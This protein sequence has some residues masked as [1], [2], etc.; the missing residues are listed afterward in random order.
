[1]TTTAAHT[2]A[3]SGWVTPA[4]LS[5]RFADRLSAGTLGHDDLKEHFRSLD[6][7][8]LAGAAQGDCIAAL[9]A[10]I[11]AARK[12]DRLGRGLLVIGANVRA[13]FGDVDGAV[14]LMVTAR[15][16]RPEGF[17]GSHPQAAI[18]RL[19]TFGTDVVSRFLTELR[20]AGVPVEPERQGLEGVQTTA[21]ITAAIDELE[22][23]G[24]FRDVVAAGRAF[25]ALRAAS[26]RTAE[27]A[28]RLFRLA[29]QTV[30][31]TP[32]TL[33]DALLVLSELGAADD[34]AMLLDEARAAGV[35]PA[36]LH[37]VTHLTALNNALRYEESLAA[38]QA[39]L[40]EGHPANARAR[41]AQ[42]TA[43]CWAE[44]P[45][46][47]RAALR[48][49]AEAVRAGTVEDPAASLLTTVLNGLVHDDTGDM[50]DV[51]EHTADV[52]DW[53]DHHRQL[54]TS[55]TRR[56]RSLADHARALAA[57]SRL[58]RATQSELEA[59]VKLASDRHGDD[60]IDA[61]SRVCAA[62]PSAGV[63]LGLPLA[64]AQLERGDLAGAEETARSTGAPEAAEAVAFAY[65]AAGDMDGALRTAR[66][67]EPEGGSAPDGGPRAVPLPHPPA[68]I[69]K[70]VRVLAI[71]R[72][73]E[74]AEEWLAGYA[75][76]CWPA[77]A[78]EGLAAAYRRGKGNVSAIEGVMRRMRQ[79]GTR[80]TGDVWAQLLY[81]LPR[82][83]RTARVRDALRA[84]KY[85]RAQPTAAFFT[86][87]IVGALQPAKVRV[88]NGASA[89]AAAWE[90][91]RTA[92]AEGEAVLAQALDALTPPDGSG[93]LPERWFSPAQLL[94]IARAYPLTRRPYAQ[95][96]A[97]VEVRLAEE[98]EP[99][100]QFGAFLGALAAAHARAELTAGIARL[101]AI[102]ERV[103][104]ADRPELAEALL[105][106]LT[107]DPDETVR[108]VQ[109]ECQRGLLASDLVADAAG[110]ALA[111]TGDAAPVERVL[112]EAEPP[113]PEEQAERLVSV[114]VLAFDDAGQREDARRLRVAAQSRGL[115]LSPT[116]LGVLLAT[117]RPTVPVVEDLGPVWT[118]AQ[119]AAY[120]GLLH[121]EIANQLQI[122]RSR[123]RL[124]GTALGHLRANLPP[125]VA[126]ENARY[127]EALERVERALHENQDEQQRTIDKIVAA[128]DQERTSAGTVPVL[129]SMTVVAQQMASVAEEAHTTI[130][131]VNRDECARLHVRGHATLL[132]FA[133]HNLISNGIKAHGRFK[134]DVRR[135]IELMATFAESTREDLAVAPYGWVIVSVRDHGDGV[136]DDLPDNVANWSMPGQPGLGA[137]IGL[138]RTE[139]MI[140]LS[141]G[142]LWVDQSV[143][144]GSRFS[145]RLPSAA[146]RQTRGAQ[147]T[148]REDSS[149]A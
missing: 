106:S 88:P 69:G 41:R 34:S 126:A 98:N 49:W 122:N 53:N 105:D 26:G 50:V 85:D 145:F 54:V 128:A 18:R 74:A 124:L 115:D 45:G 20:S 92:I 142:Q 130:Q 84:M 31:L 104:V 11:D 5:A 64:T 102:A 51:V 131:V 55:A 38:Y 35:E 143:T 37:R 8:A 90:N 76:E 16:L 48:D 87:A 91:A 23:D 101:R 39:Y 138:S 99:E 7:L 22:Q 65:L 121:H 112:D 96:D 66:L 94:E 29:V 58:R 111:R 59:L 68:L 61:L 147:T 42:L 123:T 2:E 118:T 73:T 139:N 33:N 36:A 80:P 78:W 135:D 119:L 67:F 13:V 44:R 70:M 107:G 120:N 129:D 141:G 127:L 3:T 82:A 114:A 17:T 15:Q 75:E 110:R 113:L 21:E 97:A 103:G 125:E 27:H 56:S 28:V 149:H 137:G 9:D 81:A 71:K 32:R 30:E 136:P 10:M 72:G 79:A 40:A 100:E 108:A 95:V 52:F 63:V 46:E 25:A 146:R 60:V 116:A 57:F 77:A 140:R 133:L 89:E 134:D 1:M 83:K 117:D 62:D 148:P 19:T 6:A 4:E 93:H 47:A 14:R 86:A 12:A 24:G 144:E 109:A 132:Q 43:L